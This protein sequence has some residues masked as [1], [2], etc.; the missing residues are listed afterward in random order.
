LVTISLKQL[1][2]TIIAMDRARHG[3]GAL[4]IE[5]SVALVF[6]NAQMVG[7]IVEL[8]PDHIEHRTAVDR[9]AHGEFA[10]LG[11]KAAQA[12]GRPGVSVEGETPRRR[13]AQRGCS[14][15]AS[16]S[17]AAD[18]SR[19]DAAALVAT[20]E[21]VVDASRRLCSDAGPAPRM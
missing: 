21:H 14:A 9:C 5:Q 20:V 8:P 10:F 3:D 12:N 6:W 13:E 17:A 11:K 18:G 4:R 19:G 7:N 15:P 1:D 16:T 2:P